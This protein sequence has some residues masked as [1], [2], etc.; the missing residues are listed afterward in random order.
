MK[1]VGEL[2]RMQVHVSCYLC[3]RAFLLVILDFLK[4]LSLP[5]FVCLF[6][7]RTATAL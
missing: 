3:R 4:P 1:P 6:S 5:V 7:M 2:H